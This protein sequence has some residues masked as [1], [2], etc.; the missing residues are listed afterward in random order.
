MTT[1]D[2]TQGHVW[3]VGDELAVDAGWYGGWQIHKIEHIT[4]T[5]R[6]KCAHYTLNPDLSI[7][8]SRGSGYRTGPYR[9]YAVTPSIRATMQRHADLRLLKNKKWEDLNDT[10]LHYVAFI[11]E[12]VQN[13]YDPEKVE[14]GFI[15]TTSLHNP[16]PSGRITTVPVKAD[17]ENVE[18]T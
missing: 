4:P 5:G 18:P 12:A 3:K 1:N 10:Q 13:G 16:D 8:R 14:L 2:P 7:R 15:D 17:T 6:I 9:M 11:L